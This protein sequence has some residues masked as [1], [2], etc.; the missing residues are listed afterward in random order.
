MAQKAAD[1]FG[2]ADIMAR[3]YAGVSTEDRVVGKG[4]K[5]QTVWGLK[6]IKEK[7]TTIG[8]ELGSNGNKYNDDL[9]QR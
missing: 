3:S 6:T 8:E 7:A 1:E 9:A 4:K 5:K 2:D